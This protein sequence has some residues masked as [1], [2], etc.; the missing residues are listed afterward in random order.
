[1]FLSV[2]LLPNCIQLCYHIGMSHWES[3]NEIGLDNYGIVTTSNAKGLCNTSIE[4]PRWAKNGRLENL[5][6]GV[7][8]LSQ[9]VPSE[10]DQ[11]AEAVAH[12]GEDS[13]V[14]GISVLAMH[15]LALVNP[16]KI[17]VAATARKRRSLPQWIEV[18]RPSKNVQ[19]DDFNGI[20][21]QSVADAI[22]TCKN[23][24]MRERLVSA[25]I[26]AKRRG[27]IDYKEAQELEKEL[28]I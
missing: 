9:Y 26:D 11:Y 28:K 16:S 24:L 13:F 17:T 18:V 7:Y 5:G 19:R 21:S 4:L 6:R 25:V 15:N 22:R 1:M 27:L 3:I 8:R 14:Y 12:V 2:N 10:Y 20:R 23:S